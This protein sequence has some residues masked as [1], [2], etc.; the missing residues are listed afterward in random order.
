MKPI[1]TTHARQRMAQRGVS[2]S[3]VEDVLANHHASY[4]D[5]AGNRNYVGHVNGKH[6]RVVVRGD[7]NPPPAVVITVIRI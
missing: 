2:E 1:Y 7:G 3:E 4:A 6:V 5:P